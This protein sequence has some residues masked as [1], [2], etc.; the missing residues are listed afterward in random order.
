MT[1]YLGNWGSVQLVSLWTGLFSK[2]QFLLAGGCPHTRALLHPRSLW[3]PCPLPGCSLLSRCSAGTF[4]LDGERFLR[5]VQPLEIQVWAPAAGLPCTLAALGRVLPG[6]NLLVFD[7]T[8][9][10]AEGLATLVAFVGLLAGVDTLMHYE[11]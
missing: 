8:V 6:V 10:L 11:G 2:G 5:A 4:E 1:H 9:V 7:K 3:S